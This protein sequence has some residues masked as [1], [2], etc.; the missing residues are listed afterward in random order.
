[1]IRNLVTGAV[2]AGAGAGLCAASMQFLFVVPLLVEGELYEAGARVHFATDGTTQSTATAV[3][4]GTDWAR[5]GMTMAFN[6]ITYAGFAFLL[7]AAMLVARSRGRRITARSGLI[8]GLCGFAAV[9]LA[10]AF[11]M[12]PGLPGTIQAE[13][14]ARQTWWIVTILATAGGMVLIAFARPALAFAGPVLVLAPH[15]VGAPSL[16][17][18]FGVAPPELAAEF[19]SRSLGAAAAGWTILGGLCAFFLGRPAKSPIPAHA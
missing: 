1:M 10:P 7:M 4:L 19:A 5:H 6:L 13:V 3:S 9:Q 15:L 2:F 16:E 14:W 12:P 18:Y 11:G 8:W 17:T